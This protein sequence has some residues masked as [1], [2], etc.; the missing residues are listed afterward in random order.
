M[1]YA[2]IIGLILSV[3]GGIVWAQRHTEGQQLRTALEKSVVLEPGPT[4]ELTDQ[5]G[6]SSSERQLAPA[7]YKDPP[8]A[9]TRQQNSPYPVTP[10]SQETSEG[11]NRQLKNAV[12]KVNK[13]E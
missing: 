11:S 4:S 12:E 8:P 7:L 6:P 10:P 1:R 9:A 13:P 2:K 5:P 3:I